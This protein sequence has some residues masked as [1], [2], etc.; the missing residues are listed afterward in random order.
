M[1]NDCEINEFKF[2]M[3][4]RTAET[5]NDRYIQNDMFNLS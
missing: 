4:K 3:T 5:L 1:K 2:V